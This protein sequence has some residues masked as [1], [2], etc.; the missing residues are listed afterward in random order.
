MSAP[1]SLR[2][3]QLWIAR[4]LADPELTKGEKLVAIRIALHMHLS[5]GTCNPSARTLARET[6]QTERSALR[7][8][9]RLERKGL[10]SHTGSKGYRSN[11]YALRPTVSRPAKS[12]RKQQ[13]LSA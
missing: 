5:S 9:S 6:V 3:W 12:P 7:A 1:M 4:V 8:I 10:L 13:R 11:N 2:D